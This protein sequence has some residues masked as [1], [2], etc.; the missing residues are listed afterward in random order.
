M[1]KRQVHPWEWQHPFGYSQ[2][3]RVDGPA[4]IVYMAGHVPIAPD[5]RALADAD[6]DTQAR[7]VFGN[8]QGVLE[9]AGASFE[10][11][12]KVTVFLTDISHLQ[13]Y[14]RIKAE[15]VTG[16]QPASTALEVSTLA[17]PGL[18]IE[19]EATAVL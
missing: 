14:R 11:V 13:D 12:V 6:F 1:E 4:T 17:V 9:E 7:Q 19:V 18:M 15:L 16:R 2:A 3:W 10:D 8:L 5:G